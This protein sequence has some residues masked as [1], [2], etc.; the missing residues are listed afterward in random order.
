MRILSNEE[1]VEWC[2]ERGYPTYE[3]P[4][5]TV[6]RASERPE[7]FHS[8][9]FRTP[10]D[11]GRRVWLARELLSLLNP[12]PE[13]LLWIGDWSV[14]PTCEHMPLFG[15]LR[16]AL[17]ENRPLIEA[18]GHV[19]SPA[20]ADD[21]LSLLVLSM[22]FSWGAHVIHGS[23]RDVIHVDH[24]DEGWFA[25]RDHKVT[26]AAAVRLESVAGPNAAQQA[27]AD[28]PSTARLN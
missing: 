8:V 13:L 9:E 19:L 16:A 2:R 4:G 14:W 17:G 28:G 6:P 20:D 1:C 5:H 3:S 7:N 11:S 10:A 25:S 23:G 26:E 21:A 22:L 18:P 15:R 24:H 12:K 27:V